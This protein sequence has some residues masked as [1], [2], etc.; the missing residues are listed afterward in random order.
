M[1]SSATVP[2]TRATH[3]PW[4]S[5]IAILCAPLLSVLDVFI[6]NIAIPAIKSDLRASNSDVELVIAG[7][8]IGFSAFLITGGRAGDQYGRKR[9]F[10][11]GLAL[12]TLMSCLCG[13]APTVSQLIG[14][15]FLQGVSAAFMLPQAIALI[16]LSFPDARDR[17]RAFG[18]YG[19]TLGIASMLGLY[20]GGW[21]VGMHPG[22]AGWR[23]IFLVNLPIG[24]A[25]TLAAGRLLAE[26]PRNAAQRF[27]V[28]GVAL[29]TAA[30]IAVVY[31]LGVGRER[32]WP[33]WSIAL[34]ATGVVLLVVFVAQQAR[35][36]RSGRNPLLDVRLFDYPSFN[37]G[38]LVLTFFF[39]VHNSFLLMSTVFL[40]S[41]L[42]VAA[43]D[44]GLTFV[45]F[46][47]GFLVSSWLSIRLLARFGARM[48][49]FGLAVMVIALVGQ[50]SLAPT[51]AASLGALRLMLLVYGLGSGLV[52]TTL[53]N[54][55]LRGL[56]AEFAGG[57]A[58]VYTTFQQVASALGITLIGG[59]FFHA[60]HPADP[61]T[62]IR[63]YRIGLAADM[64]CL[65]VAAVLLEGLVTHAAPHRAADRLEFQPAE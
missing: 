20:L 27:D 38:V 8:L 21:L 59:V 19:I 12:F 37:R 44:A 49:Q 52:L 17:N 63:A 53:L 25:A 7:Y 60:W 39:A 34:L 55:A 4:A 32:G 61:S 54:V 28:G 10:I 1:T 64:A 3:S 35:Q 26:T 47:A 22:I 14:Y 36:L 2:A 42:R 31:P 24:I 13:L 45:Y 9:V 23:L 11:W 40:Q 51:F 56:P 6:V 41:G 50:V 65:L 62:F 30:L 5:L 43:Y 48:L 16:Q 18:Y 29:L 15:R 33:V 58:G 57:A 46:G